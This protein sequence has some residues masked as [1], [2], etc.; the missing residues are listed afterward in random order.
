MWF[1]PISAVT[2][3]RGGDVCIRQLATN[4]SGR[5]Q[6]FLRTS[7]ILICGHLTVAH[8]FRLSIVRKIFSQF[9]MS[10]W[11]LQSIHSNNVACKKLE[12]PP[13]P[14]KENPI[15]LFSI[16]LS[17]QRLWK[18]V[19]MNLIVNGSNKSFVLLITEV[20]GSRKCLDMIGGW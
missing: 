5:W 7:H 16:S 3:A 4:E 6:R 12:S 2:T 10:S 11:T 15:Q 18:M 14:N 20:S 17:Q 19:F 1:H 13:L 9:S 8:L